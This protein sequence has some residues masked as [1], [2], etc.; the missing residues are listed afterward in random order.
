M[1]TPISTA[2]GSRGGLETSTASAR[3]CNVN[4]LLDVNED[5]TFS[6]TTDLVPISHGS[7]SHH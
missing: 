6:L 7:S 3:Q 2:A 1:V 4:N 5:T